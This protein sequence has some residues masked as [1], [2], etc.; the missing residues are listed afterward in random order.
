M[1][2][3][4]LAEAVVARIAAVGW[5]ADPL[6]PI[7][8]AT[9]AAAGLVPAAERKNAAIRRAGA[10][11]ATVRPAF[12]LIAAPDD[13]FVVTEAAAALV[14]Q[15]ATAVARCM[16]RPARAAVGLASSSEATCRLISA[17]RTAAAATCMGQGRQRGA[18]DEPTSHH[19]TIPGVKAQTGENTL[20]LRYR[21]ANSP[22]SRKSR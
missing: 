2:T 14:E 9:A 1:R 18:D 5:I 12:V 6:T 20:A 19:G 21:P 22:Q 7:D 17:A 15:A 13:R 3:G 8:F 11:L 16:A 4:P 10:R